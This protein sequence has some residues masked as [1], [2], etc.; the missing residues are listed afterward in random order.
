MPA[1]GLAKPPE[2]DKLRQIASLPPMHISLILFVDQHDGF[3]FPGKEPETDSQISQLRGALR[4]DDTDAD[5]YYRLGQLHENKW[6]KQGANEAYTKAVELYRQ[7]VRAE[8]ENFVLLSEFGTALVAVEQET[9]GEA[10]LRQAVER[11]PKAWECWVALGN[12]LVT[13]AYKEIRKAGMQPSKEEEP[14][15]SRSGFTFPG[16]GRLPF[17]P[18]SIKSTSEPEFVLARDCLAKAETYFDRAV[19]VAKKE[20]RVYLKRAWFDFFRASVEILKDNGQSKQPLTRLAA[21]LKKAAELNPQDELAVGS[22]AFWEVFSSW[23][24]AGGL[25]GAFE[26]RLPGVYFDWRI[27]LIAKKDTWKNLPEATKNSVIRA[28][29]RLEELAQK[30]NAASAV[31]AAEMVAYFQFKVIGNY[32]AAAKSF[33]RLATLDPQ[34]ETAWDLLTICWGMADNDDQSIIVCKERLRLKDSAHNHFMLAK[35]YERTNQLK[36]A[37]DQIRVGL[38]MEPDDFLANLSLGVLLLKRGD[39]PEVLAEAGQCLKKANS[40]LSKDSSPEERSDYSATNALYLALTGNIN[41]AKRN[42]QQALESD[43]DNEVAARALEILGE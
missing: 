10:V 5:R 29:K 6:D 38:K 27:I 16:F 21:D 14:K 3:L 13:K 25:V 33:R 23:T 34:N 12:S 26:F 39:N 36:E 42:F 18:V 24:D 37:E 31:R 11:A 8:P 32:G 19:A 41:E 15:E 28:M 4:G 43:P 17:Y 7:K 35:V 30:E 2:L 22:A 9:E 40:A 20:P 1:G